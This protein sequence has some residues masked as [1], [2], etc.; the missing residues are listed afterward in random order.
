VRKRTIVLLG[1][2]LLTSAGGFWATVYRPWEGGPRCKGM[3]E[4][5]WSRAIKKGQRL[6]DPSLLGKLETFCGLYTDA[7][8]PAILLGDAA[9]VPVLVRLLRSEDEEVSL[10]ARAI[11]LHVAAGRGTSNALRALSEA[12]KDENPDVRLAVSRILQIGKARKAQAE[13]DNAL[14][15]KMIR[16]VKRGQ[17]GLARP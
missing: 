17:P 16:A 12:G 13:F 8:L 10:K 5:Y 3:S 1:V 6:G 9:A 4:A 11:L 14:A 2:L 7:G 15:R